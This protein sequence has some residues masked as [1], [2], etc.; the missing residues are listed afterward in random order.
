MA[1][2]E[3]ITITKHTPTYYSDFMMDFNKNPVTGLLAKVTNGDAVAQ[4]IKMLVLTRLHERLYQ[5]TLGS[6]AHA[7]LFDM[8]DTMTTH[9]LHSTITQCIKNHEPRAQVQDVQ[10]LE[11]T[12]Q[13]AYRVTVLFN[14]INIHDQLFQVNMILKRVR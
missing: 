8:V 4:S 1:R 12:D 2:S 11:L 14:L 7:L 5:P 10:V 3:N 9:G 6:K 13:N